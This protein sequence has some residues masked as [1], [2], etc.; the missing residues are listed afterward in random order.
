MPSGK[1]RICAVGGFLLAQAAVAVADAS[2]ATPFDPHALL[3]A[4]LMAN[5]ATT[6]ADGPRNAPM[7]FLWEDGAIWLP[8]DTSA[9]SVRRIADDPRVAVDV[10]RFDPDTGV[11]LH[12]GLRGRA[13][14]VAMDGDRFRR[15]LA[16]YLGP[17]AAA[18]NP[19]FIANIARIGAPDG[20][21]IRLQPD[22]TFTNNVSFFRTGPELAWP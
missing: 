16:R 17:D 18:W 9:S 20:R 19:W 10:A 12:L 2:M 6:C 14:V 22:S 4:P 21:F 5:L 7:W 13:Q 11:L 1:G 15:L 3:N 8:S